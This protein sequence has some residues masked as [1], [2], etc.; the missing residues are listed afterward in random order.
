MGKFNFTDE[1]K[2]EAVAQIVERGYSTADVSQR[3][4]VSTHSL[5]AWVIPPFLTG[6]I[7]RI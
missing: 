5:Y 6:H 3:L 7:C 1:F 2:R 4:G